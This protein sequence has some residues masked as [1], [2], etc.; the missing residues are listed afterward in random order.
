MIG[1]PAP[2]GPASKPAMAVV[3]PDAIGPSDRSAWN[4]P[5]RSYRW[6]RTG[7]TP[8]PGLSASTRKNPVKPSRVPTTVPRVS[9]TRAQRRL[10]P[11]SGQTRN[12]WA[13]RP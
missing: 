3:C 11:T 13:T 2:S 6:T 8:G 7:A 9:V 4:T 10:A 12:G 1:M 5:V